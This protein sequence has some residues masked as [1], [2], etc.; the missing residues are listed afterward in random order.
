M[1]R[2]AVVIRRAPLGSV[3]T[4]EALRVGVG[5]TLAENR[6]T[7]LFLDDGVWAATPLQPKAVGGAE[8]AKHIEALKTLGHSVVADA[9]SMAARGIAAV[10]PEVEVRPR[11][12]VLRILGEADAVFAF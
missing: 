5:Q 7:A 8:H 10:L 3:R 4:G 12:E 11:A 6:V 1:K 9:G 2:V